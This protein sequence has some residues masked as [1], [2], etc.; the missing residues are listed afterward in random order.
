MPYVKL[1]VKR[2]ER[3]GRRYMSYQVTA[4][5]PLVEELGWEQG[6]ILYVYVKNGELI[7]RYKKGPKKGT[8]T[9]LEI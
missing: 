8:Q 9:K 7:Y 2:W 6:A 1:R 3:K 4:S 5:K